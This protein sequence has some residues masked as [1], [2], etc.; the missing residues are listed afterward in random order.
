MRTVRSR[1][2]LWAS[3]PAV[4]TGKTPDRTIDKRVGIVW[5]AQP[6]KGR[7]DAT[8]EMRTRTIIEA[9]ISK[10]G[11]KTYSGPFNPPDAGRDAAPRFTP[12]GKCF[13]KPSRCISDAQC[14]PPFS[15]CQEGACC[16]GII[17]PE[18]C[19]CTCA[20]GPPCPTEQACC[21]GDG[22]GC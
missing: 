9:A 1:R 7:L 15:T 11:G 13:G 3:K 16:S 21:T 20:G 22:R 5:Y 17:N 18:T 6:Y 14:G 12:P 2:G 8:D 4:F 10:D 19:V